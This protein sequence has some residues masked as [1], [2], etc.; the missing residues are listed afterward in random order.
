MR[1]GIGSTHSVMTSSLQKTSCLPSWKCPRATRHRLKS[2]F[3]RY[4][5]NIIALF[6]QFFVLFL[7]FLW[8]P[9]LWFSIKWPFLFLTFFFLRQNKPKWRNFTHFFWRQFCMTVQKKKHQLSF[10]TSVWDTPSFFFSLSAYFSFYFCL[11]KILKL[12][13]WRSG[14]IFMFSSDYITYITASIPFK[15]FHRQYILLHLYIL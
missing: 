13:A 9:F 10:H 11:T 3:F 4:Y 1:L 12:G 15:Q 6:F 5:I 2:E 14:L 8:P 7:P